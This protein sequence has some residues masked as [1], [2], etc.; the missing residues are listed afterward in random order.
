MREIPKKRLNR[1]DSKAATLAARRW[2]PAV[3][4]LAIA[5]ACSAPETLVVGSR[6]GDPNAQP[7]PMVRG[8]LVALDKQLRRAHCVE[9][10]GEFRVATSPGVRRVLLE[11]GVEDGPANV[12][13]SIRQGETV[14]FDS[15]LGPDDIGWREH[16]VELSAAGG[17]LAFI[18]EGTE[19]TEGTTACW[20]GVTFLGPSE[21]DRPNVILLSLDTLGAN[22]LGAFGGGSDVSPH[23]DA[24]LADS[25]SFRRAY[26][27][28]PNTLVSHSSL[29]S[30]QYPIHH[31]RYGRFLAPLNSLVG[32]LAD[33]GFYTIGFTE[34]AYV[35]ASLG[36]HQGFDRYREVLSPTDLRIP[37]NAPATFGQ[38]RDW[39]ERFG[40]DTRFFLFVHTYEVHSPYVPRQ[41]ADRAVANRLTPGDERFFDPTSFSPMMSRH[42]SGERLMPRRDI[43]RLAAL[44]SGEIHALDREVRALLDSIDELGLT[45][46]TLIVLTSDHG[47]QFGERGRLGHGSTLDNRVLHVPLGFHWPDGIVPGSSDSPVELVDVM[48]TIL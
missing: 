1:L 38:A 36:F 14:I 44:Y 2:S 4:W 33:A 9:A 10:G 26:A 8:R 7:D 37:G 46:R 43:D 22:Y 3:C 47:E 28:Y 13:F 39:L 27:Q 41:R 31:N 40:R 48:P 42:S 19:R 12:R 5:L 29:F 23:M 32:S 6:L 20:G 24:F 30:A 35:G 16:A 25:F 34:N 21:T 11:I 15:A 17:A 18:T 45:R